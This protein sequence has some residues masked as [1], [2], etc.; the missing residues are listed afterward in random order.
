VE[1][2]PLD[3][4]AVLAQ[5]ALRG[6]V[7]RR[8]VPDRIV[9]SQ[10]GTGS[11]DHRGHE[12]AGESLAPVA[13]HEGENDFGLGH[14]FDLDTRQAGPAD[15]RGRAAV[16]QAPDAVAVCLPVPQVSLDHHLYFGPGPLP[17]E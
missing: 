13:G 10:V 6:D 8:C 15:E 11:F 9:E 16:T 14:A 1:D 4:E 12:L 3:G 7:A 5:D 2:V 17:A